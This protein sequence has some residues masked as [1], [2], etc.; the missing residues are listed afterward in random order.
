MSKLLKHANIYDLFLFLHLYAYI[1]AK[2]LTMS[3][4]NNLTIKI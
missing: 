2:C 1:N 4:K 3:I